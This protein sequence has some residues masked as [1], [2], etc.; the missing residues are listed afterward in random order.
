MS[1]RFLDEL[2]RARQAPLTPDPDFGSWITN[3]H[4][5]AEPASAAAAA[6]QLPFSLLFK[7]A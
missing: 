6:G 2:E 4:P 3:A 5:F 1:G 7:G